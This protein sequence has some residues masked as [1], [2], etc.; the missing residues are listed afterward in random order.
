MTVPKLSPQPRAETLAWAAQARRA[1]SGGAAT[2]PRRAGNV[3]ASFTA[4]LSE[5][6]AT[7]GAKPIASR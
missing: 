4:F 2:L 6:T 5:W 7:V 1:L 3:P